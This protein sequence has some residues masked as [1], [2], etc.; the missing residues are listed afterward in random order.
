ML[1]RPDRILGQIIRCT[2]RGEASLT[3]QGWCK[4]NLGPLTPCPLSHEGRG[5]IPHQKAVRLPSPRVGEGLG[6]G[7][8]R[9][10]IVMYL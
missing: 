4:D 9:R 6:V 2:R 5:G 3:N 1:T 10:H 8:V 7:V